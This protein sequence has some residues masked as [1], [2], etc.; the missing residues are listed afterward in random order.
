M[1]LFLIENFLDVV[2]VVFNKCVNYCEYFSLSDLG[3]IVFYD[4]K[5]LDYDLYVKL[6]KGRF[7]VV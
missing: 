3:Y 5:Y 4:F 2:E 1:I 6:F 7:F